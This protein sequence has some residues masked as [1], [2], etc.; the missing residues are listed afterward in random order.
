[1]RLKSDYRC[2]RNNKFGRIALE[3]CKKIPKKVVTTMHKF[4]PKRR[5]ADTHPAL[6]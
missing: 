6:F 4:S 1:V 2:Q 3:T 5:S